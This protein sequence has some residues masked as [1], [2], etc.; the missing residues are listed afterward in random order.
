LR[1]SVTTT[2]CHWIA[3]TVTLLV[4]FASLYSE[5]SISQPYDQ[6]MRPSLVASRDLTI[7]QL[8]HT[9]YTAEVG[10][11]QFASGITQD[12]HGFLWIVSGADLYRF[13]GVRFDRPLSSKLPPGLLNSVYGASTG[14]LWI[15]YLLGG[16]ARV[17]E[18]QVTFYPFGKD[19]P[20]GTPF[21]FRQTPDGILWVGCTN[22]LAQ[23]V[24]GAWHA[25]GKKYG[26][27]G[28]RILQMVTTKDGS[29]WV[30]GIDFAMVLRPG[31]HRFVNV[32]LAQAE[33]EILRS[34]NVEWWHYGTDS[35]AR[36]RD[37]SGALWVGT[38]QGIR[39]YRNDYTG[40]DDRAGDVETYTT[41]DGLSNNGIV[42]LHGD[43]DGDVWVTTVTGLDQFRSTPVTPIVFDKPILKPTL[44]FDANS[45]AWVGNIWNGYR[46]APDSK[47]EPTSLLGNFVSLI[48][49]D[50]LG[51][52]W[53]ANSQ[54]LYKIIDQKSV[55]VPLP[56][57]LPSRE[58]SNS[59]R[60]IAF[61]TN[62]VV[63]LSIAG[64]GLYAMR[65][66]VWQKDGGLR[67]LPDDLA[68]RLAFDGQGR[69][70]ILY[71]DG[72]IALVDH[73]AIRVYTKTDGLDLG[74]AT[75]ISATNHQIWVAGI[76]GIA[77][78]TG[79]RFIS[80][81]FADQVESKGVTGLVQTR[82]GDLWVHDDN[83]LTWI[84]GDEIR[85]AT[86]D[87]SYAVKARIFGPQ[88]GVVG[89]VDKISPLPGL[90]LSPDGRLWISMNLG[91]AWVDPN[92]VPV[93]NTKPYPVIDGLYADGKYYSGD[94]DANLPIGTRSLRIDFTAA[95]LRNPGGV[96]FEYKLGGVDRD[97]EIAQ[98]VREASYTNLRY[99]KYVFRVRASNE[100]GG[101]GDNEAAMRFTIDPHFYQMAWFKI[102]CAAL[103]AIAIWRLYLLRVNYLLSISRATVQ[104]RERI[105]RELHD[106]LLQ[107]VQGLLFLIESASRAPPDEDIRPLLRN[108][109]TSARTTIAEGRSSVVMLRGD[110]E[111]IDLVDRLVSF[112]DGLSGDFNVSFRYAV[113]GYP[114]ALDSSA[115]HELLLA[116]R[117]VLSNAFQHAKAKH[118]DLSVAFELWHLKATVADDGEGI[119]K[120]VL[121][122]GGRSGHWGLQGVRERVDA[123]RGRCQI[124]SA[125]GQG[126]VVQ[127]S[128]GSRQIYASS[129]LRRVIERSIAAS[130]R[131]ISGS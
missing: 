127:I 42:D 54:G 98:Q 122:E 59:Y 76:D 19:I 105:A 116:L 6:E 28:R 61:G 77:R 90:A 114:S 60:A 64:A 70:W 34:P 52:I 101:G 97:W 57:G 10:A 65:D 115:G 108:A 89:D 30:G 79:N 78:F 131:N 112:A 23:F 13:D 26:Y 110:E 123:L 69:L 7:K 83:G 126:T 68:L 12:T 104:E 3:A 14:D 107:S 88:D 48:A 45:V 5:S 73:G 47:P 80:L 66:G 38:A 92:N 1:H 33:E 99:G 130:G 117:E 37:N 71:S 40:Q 11:P 53:F 36:M 56:P 50:P 31:T 102:L 128:I 55:P 91:V 67:G 120:T 124:T 119:E 46:I 86:I 16:V 39:R 82:R 49:A 81:K 74:A 125:A 29:L 15:G 32:Q 24:N 75:A 87:S 121:D 58:Y 113:R 21:D 9:A 129:V 18:G 109:I 8:H 63:W 95:S 20:S 27:D 17:H 4:A 94:K 72:R 51:T 22:G 44:A 111:K 118:I 25:V 84:T 85:H 2:K 62:N 43:R 100:D 93:N 35:G 106:T 41:A 96:R 103:A